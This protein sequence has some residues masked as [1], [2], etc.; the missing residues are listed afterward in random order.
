MKRFM[1]AQ[2][3]LC[4]GVGWDSTELAEFADEAFEYFESTDELLGAKAGRLGVRSSDEWY[5]IIIDLFLLHAAN[6]VYPDRS[7]TCGDICSD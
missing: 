1:F 6:L 7:C 3:F 4:T 5:F 2:V